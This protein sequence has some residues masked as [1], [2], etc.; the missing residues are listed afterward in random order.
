M[1]TRTMKKALSLILAVLMIA[2]AI[3]FTLL[4]AAAEGENPTIV[5]ATIGGCF[6]SNDKNRVMA[7]QSK[8]PGS[9][10]YDG[11]IKTDAE[12]EAYTNKAN[13]LKNAYFDADG[14]FAYIKNEAVEGGYYHVVFLELNEKSTV[15]K[16]HLWADSG[17]TSEWAG[18]NGYDIWYSADG[19][20]YQKT[21]LSFSGIRNSTQVDPT[22]YVDDNFKGGACIA[23]HMDMGGVEAKYIAIA[24]TE[25]AYGSG[26]GQSIFYEITVDGTVIVDDDAPVTTDVRFN[27]VDIYAQNGS[28]NSVNWAKEQPSSMVLDKVLHE[29]NFASARNDKDE[30]TKRVYFD[31]NGKIAYKDD[32]DFYGVVVAELSTLTKLD[33]FTI[34]S[35]NSI[36]GGW[37]D[38][39]AYDIYY[40]V[41]GVSFAAV[42]GAIFDDA[43]SAHKNVPV[44]EFPGTAT[45]GNT[46]GGIYRN[47]VDM[48]GVTAKYIAIAVKDTIPYKKAE[49]R[50]QIVLYELTA[51]GTAATVGLESGA[52]VR[53]NDPTG[54]RFT[55]FAN[56]NYV[57]G[58]KAQYGE[59][60]VK[61]GMLITPTD[62]LAN[63]TEFT[64]A[65]LDAC[66]AISGVKYLEIDAETVLEDGNNYVVNC[67]IVNIL[68]ANY[69]RSFSAVLYIK[70]NGEIVEYSA[71]NEL[72]NSR[73]V[74][75]VAEA[76]YYDVKSEADATYANEVSV[77]GVT[78]YSPY[79]EEQRNT[80]YGFFG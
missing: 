47:D 27:K 3:P 59:D 22:I 11:N 46:T 19:V 29:E 61:M 24:V 21:N 64:K 13:A 68:E 32:A 12:S 66:T 9:N 44:S 75:A 8:N 70:V 31:E 50:R 54:L 58:L 15:D 49:G 33:T 79:T 14:K 72:F 38:N 53:M 17:R 80:L 55:G 20:T 23:H 35:P 7:F 67:A 63:T 65:A 51:Q 6:P 28:G 26:S 2:L 76:A 36:G 37:L 73:S 39:E 42:E 4:P 57:D 16:L 52:A 40:S 34:W 45:S 78:M 69:N 60:N 43:I 71:F 25:F 10:I 77:D 41:D 18:P 62:Y 74:A 30:L 48:K 56:K 1:K 5:G